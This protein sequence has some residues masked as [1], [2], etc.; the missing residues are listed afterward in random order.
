MSLPGAQSEEWDLWLAMPIRTTP[1]ECREQTPEGSGGRGSLTRNEKI[2]QGRQKQWTS[3]S[4]P[5]RAVA[6][7]RWD[8]VY[9]HALRA[10]G[11]WH[12]AADGCDLSQPGSTHSC[13][14]SQFQRHRVPPLP[15]SR[16]PTDLA[17]GC[18]DLNRIKGRLSCI[19]GNVFRLW[20]S[21]EAPGA[22]H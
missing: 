22:Q 12:V 3:I 8:N 2:M 14:R 4:L 18:L 20:E 5:H 15:P 16:R 9:E 13:P 6:E 1:G 11:L 21:S 19:K 17:W 7:T 10:S